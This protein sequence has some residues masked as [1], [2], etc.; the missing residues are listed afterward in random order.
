[1]RQ[2]PKHIP[3]PVERVYWHRLYLEGTR[4]ARLAIWHIVVHWWLN[5]CQPLPTDLVLESLAGIRAREW[6]RDRPHIK[7]AVNELT[8]VL[9]PIYNKEIEKAKKRKWV[10]TLGTQAAKKARDLKESQKGHTIAPLTDAA[11]SRT[12]FTLTAPP[13]R[14]FHEGMNDDAARVA[15]LAVKDTP[16]RGFADK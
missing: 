4:S 7:Q 3:M 16:K 15:A 13:S 9:S 6:I 1:M 8:A 12:S 11:D 5:G 10:A 2:A 14:A